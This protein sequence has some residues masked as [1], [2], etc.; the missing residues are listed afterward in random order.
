MFEDSVVSRLEAQ[1]DAM[2]ADEFAALLALALA[3]GGVS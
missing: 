3:V 1:R 2:S